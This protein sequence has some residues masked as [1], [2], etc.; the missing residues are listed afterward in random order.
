MAIVD[1]LGDLFDT[2][3]NQLIG[4]ELNNPLSFLYVVLNLILQFFAILLREES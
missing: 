4:I 2:F 3:V 1:A